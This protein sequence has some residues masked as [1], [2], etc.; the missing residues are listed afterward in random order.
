MDESV[1][2]GGN[3][4]L[5]DEVTGG[6]KVRNEL[7]KSVADL[8]GNKTQLKTLLLLPGHLLDEV[9]NLLLGGVAGDEGVQVLHDVHADAAGQLIS[10]LDEGR[11]SEDERGEDEEDL[12]RGE[13]SLEERRERGGGSLP[14]F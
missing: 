1:D 13:K 3:L 11:G 8:G 12:G 10:G 6:F 7:A 2:D 4:G 5:D 14:S 9:D